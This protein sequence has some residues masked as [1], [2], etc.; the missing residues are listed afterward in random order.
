[1][2]RLSFALTSEVEQQE[3]Q[4]ADAAHQVRNRGRAAGLPAQLTMHGR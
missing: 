3:L 4:H 2:D 1:M